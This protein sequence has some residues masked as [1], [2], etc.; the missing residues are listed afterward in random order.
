MKHY[1]KPAFVLAT[2]ALLSASYV[3]ADT[4]KKMVI[5]IKA[6]NS[7]LTETDI[8]SLAVGEAKTIETGNGKVIDILRTTDGAEIYIDGQLLEMNFNDHG[9]HEEHMIRKHIE[10]VCTD[11]DETSC[12]E[13][14]LWISE[15]DEIDLEAL[16][17]KHADGEA[18]KIIILKK[19]TDTEN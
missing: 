10:I 1:L 7:E 6:D 13:E 2:I 16:H 14:M 3:Q 15:E 18:H 17:E 8:S 9:L 4:E 12:D 11:E 19:E 5:A